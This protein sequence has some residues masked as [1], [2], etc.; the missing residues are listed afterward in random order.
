MASIIRRSGTVRGR[1]RGSRVG[2]N[3]AIKA[4]SASVRS[5]A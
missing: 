5:L 2:M 4:D 3:G 1:L